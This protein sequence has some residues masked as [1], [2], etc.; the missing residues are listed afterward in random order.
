MEH[1]KEISTMVYLK[2]SYET[3][4]GRIADTTKRGVVLREGQ[5]LEDLYRERCPL[6][7]KYADITIDAEQ[8]S[9]GAVM[10]LILHYFT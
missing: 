5:T 4:H 6:Y 2:L 9:A 1:L 8:D 3:V 10:T 7:E